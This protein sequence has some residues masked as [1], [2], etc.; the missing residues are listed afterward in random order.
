MADIEPQPPPE[1]PPSAFFTRIVETITGLCLVCILTLAFLSP[2]HWSGKISIC[3]FSCVLPLMVAVRIDIFNAPNPGALLRGRL[4][5][6]ARFGSCAAVV[7]FMF[8]LWQ[9][10]WPAAFLF[11]GVCVVLVILAPEPRRVESDRDGTSPPS[12]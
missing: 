6:V 1:E 8:L 7:A 5:D 3:L 4:D 10:F 9:A 11:A 12:E 2:L